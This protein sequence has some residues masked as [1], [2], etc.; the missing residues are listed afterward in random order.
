MSRVIS[1]VRVI[2][3]HPIKSFIII[4]VIMGNIMNE[5]TPE[6]IKIMEK[7]IK[8]AGELGLYQDIDSIIENIDIRIVNKLNYRYAH[9]LDSY[10]Y[11]EAVKDLSQLFKIRKKAVAIKDKI[12]EDKLTLIREGN[13]PSLFDK[14]RNEIH[15]DITKDEELILNLSKSIDQKIIAYLEKEINK[16]FELNDQIL[17][18][19]DDS[20]KSLGIKFPY[21]KNK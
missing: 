19:R 7:Q 21:N 8:Q 1:L 3:A 15:K 2:L 17:K 10:K 14:I 9:K 20:M 6:V 16:N 11:S 4:L 13:I 18:E 12:T 5:S